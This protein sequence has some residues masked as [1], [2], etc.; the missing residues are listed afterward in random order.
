MHGISLTSQTSIL[1]VHNKKHKISGQS[2]SMS[3]IRFP[4]PQESYW[5]KQNAHDEKCFVFLMNIYIHTYSLRIVN[6]LKNFHEEHGPN[7]FPADIFKKSYED[8][9]GILQV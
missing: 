3:Q 2:H 5:A 8:C 4:I 6:Y 9:E 1:Q 7:I